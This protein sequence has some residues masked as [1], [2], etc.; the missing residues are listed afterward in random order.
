MARREHRFPFSFRAITNEITDDSEKP[1][2]VSFG[3]TV[4]IPR[5]AQISKL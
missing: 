3:L 4:G 1:N 5:V 2:M